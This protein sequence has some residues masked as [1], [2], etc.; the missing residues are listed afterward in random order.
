MNVS[1]VMIDTD[2]VTDVR[3]LLAGNLRRLRVARHLS[4]SELARATGVSK[5]TLSGIEAG[6]ANPTAETLAT[7]AAALQAPIAELL[8][9]PPQSEVRI[10]RRAAASTGSPDR[11]SLRLLEA[12]NLNGTLELSELTLPA[13]TLHQERARAAGARAHLLALQGKLIAGP[14]ERPSELAS[15]DYASFPADV[16]HSF[17]SMRTPAR[18]LAIYSHHF[19]RGL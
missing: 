8:E 1:F 6:R 2:T 15:G 9:A 7:I 16:P 3:A 5:A 13:H 19:A 10:V 14:A 18:A 17:E 12:A 4:L 11:A